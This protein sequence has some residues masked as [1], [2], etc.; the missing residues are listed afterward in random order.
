[1]LVNHRVR[2]G[3]HGGHGG[4]GKMNLMRVKFG[5]GAC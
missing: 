2:G 4:L 5:K 1:M 3:R